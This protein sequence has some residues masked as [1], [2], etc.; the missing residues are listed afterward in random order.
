[1][2]RA[3]KEDSPGQRGLAHYLRPVRPHTTW[4]QSTQRAS[5][6]RGGQL[7]S[8]EPLAE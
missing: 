8:G 7:Q 3:R 1:M 6:E 2:L 4:N 5:T